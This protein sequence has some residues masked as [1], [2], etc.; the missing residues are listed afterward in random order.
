M[1]TL[2]PLHSPYEKVSCRGSDEQSVRCYIHF[3]V[4]L[5]S[6]IIS[7]HLRI[8]ALR[9]FRQRGRIFKQSEN[10]RSFLFVC[11]RNWKRFRPVRG[12]HLRR[13]LLFYDIPIKVTR[14]TKCSM[15]PL[16]NRFRVVN[17]G[18]C[19][20]DSF[21]RLFYDSFCAMCSTSSGNLTLNTHRKRDIK[22]HMARVYVH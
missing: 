1:T 20:C 21:T 7:I 13:Q 9:I 5:R 12:Q 10:T 16:Q 6:D 15:F 17:N 22:T 14:K 19:A 2:S 11:T 3:A 18:N 8:P 4:E